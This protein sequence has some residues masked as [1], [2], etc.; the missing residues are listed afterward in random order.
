[1]LSICKYFLLTSVAY[2]LEAHSGGGGGREGVLI[3][4]IHA[5]M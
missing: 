2:I 1:M 5:I 4:L 3:Y